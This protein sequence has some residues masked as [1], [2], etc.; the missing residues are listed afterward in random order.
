MIASSK[1]EHS[2][3][4]SNRL[5]CHRR[6]CKPG[7]AKLDVAAFPHSTPSLLGFALNCAA[8]PQP[9]HSARAI[10]QDPHRTVMPGVRD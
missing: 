9:S 10:R 1:D 7:T 6:E 4:L 8:N 5:A 3:H 2:H